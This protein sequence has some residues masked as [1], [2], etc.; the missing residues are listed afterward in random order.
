M[1]AEPTLADL[2]PPAGAAVD[3]TAVDE[4]EDAGMDQVFEGYVAGQSL[5]NA[6]SDVTDLWK[7]FQE[8][9]LAFGVVL[10]GWAG[11][12]GMFGHDACLLS[13]GRRWSGGMPG[14]A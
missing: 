10:N 11:F 8:D 13:L 3:D 1:T 5:V 9:P 6:A 14:R 12:G 4:A 7:L 2:T